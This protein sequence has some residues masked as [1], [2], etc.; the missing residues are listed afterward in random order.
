MPRLRLADIKASLTDRI[1]ALA[2]HLLPNGRR[3]GR[4]WKVGSVNGEPGRSLGVVLQGAKRGIW[5]DFAT[6]EGG[7][8]LD[9]IS[10]CRGLSFS[11]SIA[12]AEA[13][14]GLTKSHSGRSTGPRLPQAPTTRIEG[15]AASTPVNPRDAQRDVNRRVHLARRIWQ[16]AQPIQGTPAQRYLR[17]RGLVG[18]IP[19]SL[20]YLG[21]LRHA[22]SRRHFPALIAA[23]QDVQGELVGIWR[24]YLERH[25]DGTWGKASV[26]P[27]KMGLGRA[28]GC[29]VRLGPAKQTLLIAEGIETA[30]SIA[31]SRPGDSV[32]AALST[33]GMRSLVLPAHVETVILC[34]DPDPPGISAAEGAARRFG[35]EG[36]RV[37]VAYPPGGFDF[38][39]LLIHGDATKADS[40]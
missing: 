21:D 28:K 27:N 19:P 14:L 15:D 13:W 26:A 22:P 12:W 11:D 9:L 36:R 16:Q 38:N 40:Q 25:P 30:L 39:D 35:A 8:A 10:A 3:E 17:A 5:K 18:P 24:I 1:D 7:D 29:A 20:R 33:S 31:L 4:E 32:W 6:G 23:V 37:R 34:A 2:P